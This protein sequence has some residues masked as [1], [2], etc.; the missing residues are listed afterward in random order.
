MKGRV[1]LHLHPNRVNPFFRLQIVAPTALA[2]LHSLEQAQHDELNANARYQ[3]S[4]NR[5]K[6]SVAKMLMDA[7]GRLSP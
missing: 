4:F 2:G 3:I 6:E 1:Y 5:T 7:F